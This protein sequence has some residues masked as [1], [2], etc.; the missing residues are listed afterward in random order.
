MG[1][2]GWLADLKN[3]EK[4]RK[5]ITLAGAGDTSADWQGALRDIAAEST[6]F[7]PTVF[8]FKRPDSQALARAAFST[9]LSAIAT[10]P[11][12]FGGNLDVHTCTS[13]CS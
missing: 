11:Q 9:M 4:A 6:T 1:R 7:D 12:L 13:P 8:G 3:N 10:I 2:R 5:V